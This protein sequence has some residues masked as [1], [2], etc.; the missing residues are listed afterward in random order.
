MLVLV[1]R[2]SGATYL[3]TGPLEEGVGG[4]GELHDTDL[5]SGQTATSTPT[6]GDAGM[7]T[8][9]GICGHGRFR[10]GFATARNEP[11]VW[12]LKTRSPGG[13]TVSH[14]RRG[15]RSP[16]RGSTHNGDC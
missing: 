3:W 11:S 15:H 2:R 4:G 12:A 1:P 10:F 9:R 7:H 6:M 14:G 5:P 13:P 8:L 16:F